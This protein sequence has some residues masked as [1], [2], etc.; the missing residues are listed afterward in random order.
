MIGDIFR[1]SKKGRAVSI[2]KHLSRRGFLAAAGAVGLGTLIVPTG[3][4]PAKAWSD[5]TPRGTPRLAFVTTT[6]Y[7]NSHAHVILENFLERYLFN[8]VPTDPGVEIASLYVDQIH[9]KDISRDVG[10]KYHVPIFKTIAETLCLGGEKLAVDGVLIIAEQGTYPVNAKGQTEYPRKAFFDEVVKVFKRS[11]RVVPVY[12]DKHLSYRWDWAKEMFDTAAQMKIPLMAGSS[13]PLAQRRPAFEIEAGTKLKDAVAI[14][15][16]PLEAYGFHA[17]ELMQSMVEFRHGGETGVREVQYLEKETLWRAAKEGLWSPQVAAEAMTAELGPEHRLV[18]SLAQEG[19]VGNE[20]ID[21]SGILVRYRDGLN[22][23][24]MI[25]SRNSNTRWNFA[26]RLEGKEK[27]AATALYGGPWQNRG[28]FKA[29]A[30]AIQHHMRTGVSPYPVE[31]TLLTTGVLA[32]AME[33]FAAKKA[34]ATPELDFGYRAQDF[35][36]FRE[37]GKTWER[38]TEKTPAPEG[39]GQAGL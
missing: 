17:L 36:A 31:R 5:E 12:N 21:T 22:G 25:V 4:G 34:V 23:M 24:A 15:A 37:M 27:I 18:K 35:K 2:S 7:P 38:I 1:R 26:C 32:A 8:G 10:T 39:V 6:F 9:A 29:L 11:A 33:S 13:V 14:H 20:V 19:K 16:G 28:L 30:H 3:C